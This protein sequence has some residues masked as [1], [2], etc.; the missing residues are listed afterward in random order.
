MGMHVPVCIVESIQD[1]RHSTRYGDGG[2]D[3]H[4]RLH[5]FIFRIG[6]KAYVEGQMVL[7]P[8]QDFCG[9]G[10]VASPSVTVTDRDEL[11]WGSSDRY[12]WKAL[13]EDS[14]N[15]LYDATAEYDEW[16]SW[17]AD[18]NDTSDVGLDA[19]GYWLL[20]DSLA[21]RMLWYSW[22]SAMG[23]EVDDEDSQMERLQ[24]AWS[25]VN[26][27]F[28]TPYSTNLR[29][30]L[31]G[32]SGTSS[33]LYCSGEQNFVCTKV[34]TMPWYTNP[35][36]GNEVRWVSFDLTGA[37]CYNEDEREYDEYEGSDLAETYG[38][39]P[40]D[41]GVPAPTM[42]TFEEHQ[43]YLGSQRNFLSRTVWRNG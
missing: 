36:S 29:D 27:S 40:P 21:D 20:A 30:T 25:R 26:N 22:I 37:S 8:A 38:V 32:G 4:M 33:S 24:M 1:P 7:M 15:D 11:S 19:F 42:T 3:S 41:H 18:R 35:N 5:K 34:Q 39:C 17:L 14:F 9:G 31:S 10:Y 43:K 6:D 23:S 16:V 28:T 13:D 2:I 12:R